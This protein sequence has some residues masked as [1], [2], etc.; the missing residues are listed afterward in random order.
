MNGTITFIQTVMILLLAIGLMDHVIVIPILLDAAKR[1]AWISVGLA[2]LAGIVWVGLLYTA[3]NKT[4]GVHIFQWIKQA[5]SPVLGHALAGIAGLYML[6]LCA[7]TLRDTSTWIHL[8]FLPRVPMLPLA[9]IFGLLC[10]I[11]AACGIRSIANTSA[12]LVP[13]VILFGIFVSLANLPNKR[14]A[15]LKPFLEM[16]MHPVWEGM[17]YAGA[18]FIEVIMLLFLQPHIRNKYS[19]VS[20]LLLTVILIGLTAGP[21]MGGIAEFGPEQLSKLRYPAYEEWRL[22]S[23]GRYIEH[24]DFL[25]IYQ[26]F[27]GA[28]VRISLT[29]FL[30]ADIVMIRSYRQKRVIMACV[31]LLSVAFSMLPFS[32]NYFLDMLRDLILPLSVLSMVIYSLI[33]I[34]LIHWK[35]RGGVPHE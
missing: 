6:V 12:L 27:S 7:V 20:V 35:K 18:G 31:F 10:F 16:G 9:F 19:L 21:I 28:F 29:M 14:Y 25:S 8:T 23:I 13:F 2:G 26:W 17:V 32:D 15:L 4:R 24:L 34:A 22:V 3:L 30:I 33:V 11:N 5:Y 1:D